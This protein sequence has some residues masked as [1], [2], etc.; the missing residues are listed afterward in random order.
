VKLEHYFLY[1]FFPFNKFLSYHFLFCIA[2]IV[3]KLSCPN[4]L[5]KEI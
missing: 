2:F 5:L 4:G 3:I 1:D